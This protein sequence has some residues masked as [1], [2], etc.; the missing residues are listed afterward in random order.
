[1]S[2]MLNVRKIK[3]RVKLPAP[4]K[5]SA[6]ALIC[7]VLNKG[8]AVITTPIF[9]RIMTTDQYGQ[10]NVFSSW[11]SILTIVI[12]FNLYAG[13]YLQGLVKFEERQKEFSSSMQGLTLVMIALWTIVYVVFRDFWNGLFELSTVQM[14]AMILLI[15]LSSVFNFWAAEQKNEYKYKA[16]VAVTL[17]ASVLS[18][19]LTIILIMHSED[20]VTA[21]ILGM[22]IVEA[23]VYVW[24]FF[25]QLKNGKKFFDA[26]LWRYALLFNLPL[27]P[28]YLSQVVLAS[29]DRIMIE[30]MVGESEAGIYSLA[31]SLAMIML[32]LNNALSQTMTPWAYRKIKEKQNAEMAPLTYSTLISVAVCNF[33]LIAFAPEAVKI[34][35]PAEYYS[36]IWVIPPVAIS[37]FYIYS[38]DLFAK[39]AFYYEK[40]GFITVAS[41]IGAILNIV[42]NYICIIKFG[43]IA[44]GYTTLICYMIYAFCHYQIMNKVCDKYCNG[45]RPYNGKIIFIISLV[46]TILGLMMLLTYNYFFIRYF[47]ILVFLIICFMMRKRFQLLFDKL[48]LL[49]K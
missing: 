42:L 39:F 4:V 13:V 35:A 6:W 14:L 43:Y 3:K 38:Y 5:A 8:V 24:L 37:V 27:V 1:M 49:R 7:G 19:T 32:I 12:S 21:R 2:N 36:A 48:V 47:V 31:Y 20:K 17:L 26:K 44:A 28:H 46:F 11:L 34:F 15:W 40:Q 16:L 18:P 30:R 45:E 25:I 22:L 29:S 23:A 41:V 10:Y 9:T 33:L